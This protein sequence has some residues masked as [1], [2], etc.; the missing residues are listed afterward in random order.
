[1]AED[2]LEEPPDPRGVVGGRLANL[3]RA[4][5]FSHANVSSAA[6]SEARKARR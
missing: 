1:V 5:G 2:A 4:Q 6:P 3:E